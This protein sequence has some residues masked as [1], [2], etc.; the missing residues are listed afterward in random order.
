MK[1]KIIVLG[2]SFNP[3]TKAHQAFLLS[4]VEALGADLGIYVPAPYAYVKKKMNKTPYP[5]EVVDEKIRMNMLLA[6]A[7]DDPRLRADDLEYHR[8]G[9]TYTYHTLETLQ[10][11]Y[12][13]AELYFLA[14]ADKLKIIPRWGYID[15]ILEKFHIIVTDRDGMN[16]WTE[17]ESDSIL[18]KH[19]D[20]FLRRA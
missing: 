20:H 6:M 13:D 10:G 14:G 18:S 5:N 15:A 16:A 19:K 8:K 17:I 11:K 2:G 9:M 1:Q 12:P 4:A 7:A 3:P